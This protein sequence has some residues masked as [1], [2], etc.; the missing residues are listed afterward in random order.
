MKKLIFAIAL[1]LPF[2]L[3]VGCSNGDGDTIVNFPEG[4]TKYFYEYGNPE[5]FD[6][7]YTITGYFIE[8]YENG[9]EEEIVV[10]YGCLEYEDNDNNS[11]YNTN[12]RDYEVRVAKDDTTYIFSFWLWPG[13]ILGGDGGENF[14]GHDYYNE[15]REKEFTFEY[16]NDEQDVYVNCKFKRP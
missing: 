1:A 14:Y 5:W 11:S 16:Y 15:L 8:D 3:F 10:A 12:H 6:T 7:D 2:A 13:N 4:S 9:G